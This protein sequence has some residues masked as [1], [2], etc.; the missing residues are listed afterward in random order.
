MYYLWKSSN[1]RL[2]ILIKIR[3][4]GYEMNW[5]ALL[6]VFLFL[7]TVYA[8]GEQEF[9][10]P[11]DVVVEMKNRF[12]KMKTFQAS[13]H[14]QTEENRKK[15]EARGL[16][17]YKQN[18]KINFT[19][20]KPAG[21][22]II[23]DGRRLW[24]YIA[25]MNALAVQDLNNQKKGKSIYDTVSYDGLVALFKN[26]HYSFRTPQQPEQ[27]DGENYYVFQ[28][29]EKVASGSFSSML[30]Y[31]SPKDHLIRFVEAFSASGRE[32][33]LKFSSIK[34]DEDLPNSLFSYEIKGNTR[35]IENPLTTN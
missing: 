9:L 12:K 30:I 23:S 18:G 34:L 13:F 2:T 22:K 8:K 14:I 4:W 24:I 1:K 3:F 7:P 29:K 27:K 15:T 11:A 25:S 33:H 17:Y 5:K 6:F 10:H 31:V 21:D 16:V 19:F 35:V 28:L 26:Y 32:V 20:N